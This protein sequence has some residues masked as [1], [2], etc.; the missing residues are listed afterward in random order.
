[1]NIGFHMIKQ[2]AVY[3]T[4]CW[5]SYACLC[6]HKEQRDCNWIEFCEISILKFWNLSEHSDFG[7][8]WAD[9]FYKLRTVYLYLHL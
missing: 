7:Q 4:F 3:Y 9:T 6:A 1:M 2:V 8:N 5:S